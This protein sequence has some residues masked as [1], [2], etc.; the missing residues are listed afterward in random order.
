MKLALCIGI[1]DYPGV[2]NDL[3]G[4]RNDAADWT[5]VLA[6]R[7]FAVRTLLDSAASGAAIR[8][9]VADLLTQATPG[10]AV[11]VTY[12]GHGTWVPDLDG[13]EPDGRD[14]AICPH[15]IAANGPLLDDELST[16]FATAA[17]GVRTVL[18]SDSCH[19]GT[20]TRLSRPL[21][22]GR[23]SSRFL[24]PSTFLTGPA[25]TAGRGPVRARPRSAALLLS[26]CR[27][28]EYS[29]DATFAGRPNGAFTYVA[30]TAL[31][32]LPAGATYRDWLRAIRAQLPSQNYPQTPALLA[33]TAQLAWPLLA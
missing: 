30:L 12:S 20:L 22:D 31:A 10:D 23:G 24:P 15:D 8:T 18:I 32:A 3:Y 11:V 21:G 33:S 5:G 29:Y 4:C 6:A 7:G 9:G 25:L 2:S 28:S 26:A 14:E 17:P 1:N 13:D 19:S 27:D 16:L